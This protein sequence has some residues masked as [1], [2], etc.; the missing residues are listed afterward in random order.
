MQRVR[1]ILSQIENHLRLRQFI[2]APLLIPQKDSSDAQ[3][4]LYQLLEEVSSC[5]KCPLHKTRTKVVFGSGSADAR[6]IFIGEAPGYYEDVQGLPFVGEAG[7]LLTKIIA[8][9]NLTREQV[10]IA[11]VLKCRPP[12]NRSPSPDEI[13]SCY[14]FLVRQIAAIRPSVI[15]VLGSI[16]AKAILKTSKPMGQI[17]GEFHKFGEIP[18][19][20]T[21][22]PAYLLRNPGDKRKVWEDMKKVRDHLASLPG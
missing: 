15:C 21:F 7:Q 6:L 10:Y 16:A 17:R 18:V 9:I 5:T 8:S 14:P 3:T 20:P 1:E 22:H 4:L 2:G 12:N 19:M 11:N 13:I